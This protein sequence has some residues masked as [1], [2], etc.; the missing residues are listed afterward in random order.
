MLLY[1]YSLYCEAITKLFIEL[2]VIN[3]TNGS[4]IMF[5]YKKHK[6]NI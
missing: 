3:N 4:L 5:L 1:D 6:K 2:Y